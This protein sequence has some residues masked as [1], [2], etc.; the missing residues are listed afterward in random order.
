[1]SVA[2]HQLL[3]RLAELGISVSTEDDSL[4]CRARK[5]AMSPEIIEVLKA[6]KSELIRL[7]RTEAASAETRMASVVSAPDQP[8]TK[9]TCNACTHFRHG[10]GSMMALGQCRSEPWDGFPGQWP[11]SQH[12]CRRFASANLN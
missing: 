2:T 12:P 7:L 9:V 3:S 10:T 1:M 5:G 11:F 4:R 6:H 8:R